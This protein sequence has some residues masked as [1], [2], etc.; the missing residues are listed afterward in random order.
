MKRVATLMVLCCLP[1]AS[2]AWNWHG[3]ARVKAQVDNRY[4]HKTQPF[5]ELW[6][7][8]F[9]DAPED[10][11]NGAVDF[12]A[13]TSEFDGGTYGKLY[14]GFLEKGFAGLGLKAKLGRFERT[15]NLGFYLVD[16]GAVA[17]TAEGNAWAVEAYG[18]RPSRIDHVRS[19]NG[20]FVAGFEARTRLLTGWGDAASAMT[21]DTLDL[22]GGYQHLQADIDSALPVVPIPPPT[23]GRIDVN[24]LLAA[25]G[26]GYAYNAI[27]ANTKQGSPDTDRLHF[28][29]NAAG[30]L[31]LTEKGAYELGLLGTYRADDSSFQDVLVSAQYD[32]DKW[33]RL[34]SSYEYFRP[35]EPYLTFRE[36]FYSA[37]ALGEQTLF[38][39]RAQCA[40][41]EALTLS[42][43]GMRATRQGDDGYGA[44]FSGSYAFTPN[45]NLS[46]EFDYLA[47]G[48]ENAK[49]GYASLF[50]SFDSRT[51]MRLNTALRYE[52]KLLYGNNRAIGA[53]AEVRYM[54]N[55]SLVFEVAG[56]YIWNTRLKEEY[57]GAVQFIYYFDNF[58]PKAM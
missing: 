37:Y 51:Q 55:S 28:A 16:G 18:G 32:P 9:Y 29:A 40:A 42:V 48:P 26:I 23:G 13:R 6:G 57:L 41:T 20:N 30:K 45:L 44:D 53:E 8:L 47:L 52:H 39:G 19:V 24:A 21:L 43:G 1:P 36:K 35:R 34:R 12:V 4:T 54:F 2:H 11:L 56:S 17:Y 7:Q 22:R 46:A 14:Q 58:Q 38:R 5:G 50:H 3:S 10:G 33:L 25:S 15:D 27:Q 49:S 31:R